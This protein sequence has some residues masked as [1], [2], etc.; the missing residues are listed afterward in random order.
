MDY[1]NLLGFG[2]LSG[3]RPEHE[4]RR[5]AARELW[6]RVGPSLVSEW[7]TEHPG[8]RPWGW[9]KWDA[10]GAREDTRACIPEDQTEYLRENNLLTANEVKALRASHA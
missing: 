7:I 10:P 1:F 6:E 9:W 5:T 2:S 4:H 3:E 8:T